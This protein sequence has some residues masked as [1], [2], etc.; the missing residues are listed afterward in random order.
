MKYFLEYNF[1][2]QFKVAIYNIDE[3]KTGS[4]FFTHTKMTTCPNKVTK[5]AGVYF[6]SIVKG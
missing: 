5:V 6:N 2:F 1:E 3:G 4:N